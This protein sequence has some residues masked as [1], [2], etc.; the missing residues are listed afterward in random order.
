M[1]IEAQ[2]NN[3]LVYSSELSIMNIFDLKDVQK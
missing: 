2:G 3:Q 1:Q